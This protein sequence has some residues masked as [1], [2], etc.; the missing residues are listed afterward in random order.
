MKTW[1]VTGGAGFIGSNFV[2]LTIAQ[3]GVR[4]INLDK[5]TYAGNLESLA[6]VLG[7]PNH[8]FV[9]GS[10]GDRALVTDLLN[11]YRPCAVVNLAAESHVDRS[12]D[13]PAEFIET[14]IV[15]TFELLEAVRAYWNRLDGDEGENFRYLQISTD[16]VYG[17]LGPAGFFAETTRYAPRSPY[18]ASK[19]AADHLVHGLSRYLWTAGANH[20]LFQKGEN[21]IW[22]LPARLS[23]QALRVQFRFNS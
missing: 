15:G 5:L 20:Q 14:N 10:I 21:I 3:A 9:H 19:A 16:E 12:I 17:S 4:I 18:A 11:R 23:F 7:S 13:G 1:L 22:L 8:V 6:A 2:M